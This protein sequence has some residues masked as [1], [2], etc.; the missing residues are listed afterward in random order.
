MDNNYSELLE[1]VRCTYQEL[2][3]DIK[4]LQNKF[5]S[6]NKQ[7]L[8]ID[9]VCVL[10]SLSKST[11]YKLTMDGLIPHYKKCKHLYFDR[12]EVELWLKENKEGGES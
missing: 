12:V 1:G 2:K 11:I 8:N 5:A 4:S 7:V 10:T 3:E 6:T 9:E